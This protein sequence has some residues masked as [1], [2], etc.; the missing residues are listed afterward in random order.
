[1]NEEVTCPFVWRFDMKCFDCKYS[2][3]LWFDEIVEESLYNCDF[4]DQ[5]FWVSD[6]G[7]KEDC[8]DFKEKE[9]EENE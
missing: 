8:G 2:R 6:F 7:L 9:Q 4:E 5:M 1:M 3:C